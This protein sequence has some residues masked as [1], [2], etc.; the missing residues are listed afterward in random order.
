MG[1]DM[2]GKKMNYFNRCNHRCKDFEDAT[3]FVS[4]SCLP[5]QYRCMPTVATPLQNVAELNII[6]KIIAKYFTVACNAVATLLPLR[7]IGYI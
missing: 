6:T 3:K 1:T 4:G 7:C 2:L 5:L